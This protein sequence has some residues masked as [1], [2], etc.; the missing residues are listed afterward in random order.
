M[1]VIFHRARAVHD[2]DGNQIFEPREPQEGEIYINPDWIAAA[3]DHTLL[4]CD[5]QI[6]VMETGAEIR[7]I[8][9]EAEQAKRIER[10]RME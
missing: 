3:Y 7:R 10:R 4:I 1:F 2:T 9:V 6:R 5:N 8:I